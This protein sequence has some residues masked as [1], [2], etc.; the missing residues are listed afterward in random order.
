MNQFIGEMFAK[1]TAFESKFHLW[2]LQLQSNDKAHFPTVKVKK[3]TD[4]MVYAGEIRFCHR[5]LAL[6]IFKSMRPLSVCFQIHLIL[7]SK[8]FQTTDLQYNEDFNVTL[9]DFYK[10]CLPGDKFPVL[11][12]HVW[13][14]TNFFWSTYFCEKLFWKVSVWR[15]TSRFWLDSER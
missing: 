1:I 3:P 10:F 9:F 13:E 11:R 4:I 2:E 5:N 15:N 7:I 14:M 8:L 6:S 12:N